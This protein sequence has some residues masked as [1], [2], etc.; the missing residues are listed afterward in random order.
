MRKKKKTE[1]GCNSHLSLVGLGA[2]TVC[3]LST[4]FHR[5]AGY[6]APICSAWQAQLLVT[7]TPYIPSTV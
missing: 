3:A 6:W 5:D 2:K 1:T 7:M 4:E